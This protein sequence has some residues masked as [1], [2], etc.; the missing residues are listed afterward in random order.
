MN[1][2]FPEVAKQFRTELRQFI[3][4]EL[5]D[6]WTLLFNHDERVTEA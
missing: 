4:E 1:L 3:T 5:P 2:D 6:W